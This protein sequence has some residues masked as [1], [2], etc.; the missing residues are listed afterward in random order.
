MQS[1]VIP[2]SVCEKLD[3]R[4]RRFWWGARD[5]SARPLCLRSWDKIF[6]PKSVRG[7]GLR[8]SYDINRALLAKWSW[9][10]ISGNSSLC[11][12]MLRGKYLRDK[13][14]I[15]VSAFPSDS[16]FWKAILALLRTRVA[17]LLNPDGSWNLPKLHAVFSQADC[18]LIQSMHRPRLA[19]ADRWI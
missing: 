7:L 13:T 12:S 10:L 5:T 15:S 14:F 18:V 2:K 16:L 8:R 19:G 3:S 11:F 6:T 9:D 4:M 1:T 17:T